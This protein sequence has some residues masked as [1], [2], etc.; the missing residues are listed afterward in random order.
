MGSIVESIR[1]YQYSNLVFSTFAVLLNAPFLIV[2]LKN[3]SLH[4]SS[5]AILGGLCCSDL[6]TGILSVSFT[7]KSISRFEGGSEDADLYSEMFQFCLQ[8][9]FVPAWYM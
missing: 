8:S 6:I 9:L 2:L 4:T 7:A 5:N 3:R 1:I